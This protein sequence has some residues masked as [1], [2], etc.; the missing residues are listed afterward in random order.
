MGSVAHCGG[1]TPP[2]P[3]SLCRRTARQE[4]GTYGASAYGLTLDTLGTGYPQKGYNSLGCGPMET[5]R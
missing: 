3:G 5:L 4:Q 1:H 2:F